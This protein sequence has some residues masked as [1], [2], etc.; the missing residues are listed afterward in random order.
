MTS[1][2]KKATLAIVILILCVVGFYFLYWVRTPVYSIHIIEKS[3]KRHDVI[4]FEKHVDMDNLYSKAFD[5]TIIAAGKIDADSILENPLA[6]GFL[7]IL[8]PTVVSAM[9][10]E[11]IEYVKG[12]KD[13][14]L[15]DN[16]EAD[17]V[18]RG[19]KDKTDVDN[20]VLKKISVVRKEG[21]QAIVA[22][23]LYNKK[24]NKNFD[25]KLKMTKLDDGKWQIK[26]ITN[27]VEFILA[28]N[29]AES[30]NLRGNI[31]RSVKG[32]RL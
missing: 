16:Q 24:L 13:D 21:N 5:D 28:V 4:T 22:L 27:L 2:Q 30:E 26:E 23:K 25:L 19:M 9:K 14:N 7:Q 20:T 31:S 1:N 15:Q 6:I 11:T 32:I 8:K 12:E 10:Y 29:K 3:I 17:A 18:L